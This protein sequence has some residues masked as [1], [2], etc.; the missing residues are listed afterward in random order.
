MKKKVFGAVLALVLCFVLVA[1]VAFAQ[2]DIEKNLNTTAEG[3][4]GPSGAPTTNLPEM[5]GNLI[6]VVLG[7]LGILMV[8]YIIWGGYLYMTGG[9]EGVKKGKAMI[10]NAAIGM[11]LMLAAYSISTFVISQVIKATG[12]PS[13]P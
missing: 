8:V 10:K 3:I 7:F 1:P 6:N 13:N 12:T 11:I 5:I 2:L 4:Y 9:D